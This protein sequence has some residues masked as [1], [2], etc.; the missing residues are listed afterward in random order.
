MSNSL[1]DTSVLWHSEVYILRSLCCIYISVRTME[2]I[3]ETV[4]VCLIVLKTY[5]IIPVIVYYEQKYQDLGKSLD[6]SGGGRKI[7]RASAIVGMRITL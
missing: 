7:K 4:C 5:S 2:V 3:P 6:C 1:T